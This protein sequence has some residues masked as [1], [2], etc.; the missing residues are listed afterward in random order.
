MLN[1][2]YFH[3]V[4]NMQIYPVTSAYI[5]FCRL[6]TGLGVIQCDKQEVLGILMSNF[7]RKNS[8]KKDVYL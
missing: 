1:T 7:E 3:E 2:L 5:P 8:V 4:L 6:S